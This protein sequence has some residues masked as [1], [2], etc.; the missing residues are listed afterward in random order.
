MKLYS[1]SESSLMRH[2]KKNMEGH[3]NSMARIHGVDSGFLEREFRCVKE[4]VRFAEFI[5]SYLKN[6]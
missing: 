6:P 4:G 2:V 1:S 3:Y 5:S